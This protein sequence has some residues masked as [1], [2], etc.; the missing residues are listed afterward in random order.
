MRNISPVL[1]T[2]LET[3]RNSPVEFSTESKCF[4]L[5][6]A[7]NNKT[8]KRGL[9]TL[10]ANLLPVPVGASQPTKRARRSRTGPEPD[11]IEWEHPRNAGS[12][13][14]SVA[15]KC[16][17]CND[18][19]HGTLVDTQLKIYTKRG[20]LG[21]CKELGSAQKVDPCVATLLDYLSHEMHMRPIASQMPIYSAEMDVA[22][23]L[24]LLV[25]DDETLSKLHLIEVKSSV[26]NTSDNYERLRGRLAR[27]TLRGTPLSYYSR[28]QVQLWTM[29]QML[30]EMRVPIASAS[31]MRVSPGFVFQYPLNP[32]YKTRSKR[33]ICAIATQTGQKRR[34]KRLKRQIGT[35]PL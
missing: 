34:R 14:L 23:A 24:D 26:R 29:Q 27:T 1:R 17:A 9:T 11:A 30:A 8:R 3:L 16:L 2:A 7:E 25:T 28:H 21:L 5:R 19:V 6:A 31:V 22:T 18:R 12:R 32:W 15:K 4:V 35:S 20:W 33:F 13:L 10:L